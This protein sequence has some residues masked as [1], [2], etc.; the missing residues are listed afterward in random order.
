MRSGATTYCNLQVTQSPL[1][2]VLTGPTA[3]ANL[4]PRPLRPRRITRTFCLLPVPRPLP[5][6]LARAGPATSSAEGT[7]FMEQP[8]LVG[9][10][11]RCMNKRHRTKGRRT[12]AIIALAA[13]L[14]TLGNSTLAASFGDRLAVAAVERTHHKVRYDPAYVEIAYPWGDVPADR[15]VCSDEVIR[16]YR[17]LGIDLQQLVHIDMMSDFSRYPNLPK[18][19]RSEPD[20]NIDHRRVL[21]LG[22]F[23]TRHGH[24]LTPS[25]RPEDYRPGDIVTWT[26]PPDLPHIGIVVN[27]RGADLKRYMI[28]HN[29]GKGPQIED[30]LFDWPVTGHF[31]FTDEE[32][33]RLAP[34]KAIKER[35]WAL[36]GEF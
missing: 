8:Y 20:P 14:G 35:G 22:T 2:S 1:G 7:E 23:F 21:N 17:A 15:G 24:S 10:L 12:G 27:R 30:R 32:A 28:V 11:M 19:E 33:R 18:W 6:W 34:I 16:S 26:V 36:G 31:R 4:S 13:L 3:L 29:I 25:D 9:Q 5:K